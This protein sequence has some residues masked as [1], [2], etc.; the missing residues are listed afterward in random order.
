VEL[1]N[2]IACDLM[3]PFEIP[4]FDEGKYVLTICNLS[5]SYSEL[6]ILKKKDETTKLLI[7]V[8]NRFK[9]ENG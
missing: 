6:R 9:T 5:S 8:I 7:E 3:G 4:T 2:V 1:L